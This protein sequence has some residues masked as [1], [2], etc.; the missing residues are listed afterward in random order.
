MEYMLSNVFS[1]AKIP[2][3]NKSDAYICSVLIFWSRKDT[4]IAVFIPWEISVQKYLKLLS[5]Y[6]EFFVNCVTWEKL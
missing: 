4:Y 1:L 5:L 2:K 6:L 3:Y